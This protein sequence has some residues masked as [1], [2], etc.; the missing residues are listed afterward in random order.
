MTAGMGLR[1]LA[2]LNAV[3]AQIEAH[4]ETWDQEE[5]RCETGMCVAGWM[6][7]LGGGTWLTGPYDVHSA[8]L[9]IE[10]S[11]ANNAR[12]KEL[13]DGREGIYADERARRLLGADPGGLFDPD[14]SLSDIKAIRDELY[15]EAIDR[16]EET[17]P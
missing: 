15:A 9:V 14:N 2:L 11:D 6:C 17:R 13:S 1:G 4:P 7:E 16:A 5:W 8:L 10:D 3:I 12:T